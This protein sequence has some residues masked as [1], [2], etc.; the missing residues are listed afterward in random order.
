MW[1]PSDLGLYFH[2][3]AKIKVITSQFNLDGKLGSP[4]SIYQVSWP[5][6]LYVGFSFELFLQFIFRFL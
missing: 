3:T 6:A 4:N 5:L 1:L 2:V